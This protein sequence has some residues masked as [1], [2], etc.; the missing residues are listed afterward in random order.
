MIAQQEL[1][2]KSGPPAVGT[3]LSVDP[4]SPFPLTQEK[5]SWA[6][7]DRSLHHGATPVALLSVGIAWNIHDMKL[8][9]PG[10]ACL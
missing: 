2:F 4:Q 10:G 7:Y 9:T 6:A 1:T 8:K 3:L 5:E